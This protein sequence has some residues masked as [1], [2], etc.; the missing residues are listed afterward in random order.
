MKQNVRTRMVNASAD[1]SESS[2]LERERFDM[3]QGR[4]KLGRPERLRVCG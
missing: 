1:Y 4:S 3:S 2:D